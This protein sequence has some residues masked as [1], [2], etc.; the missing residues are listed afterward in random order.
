MACG[1]QEQT[2]G[3][4]IFY[5]ASYSKLALLTENGP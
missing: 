4:K 5:S 1:K 2:I 3:E